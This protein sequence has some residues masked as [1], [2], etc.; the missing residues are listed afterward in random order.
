M[1]LHGSEPTERLVRPPEDYRP[2][3][4]RVHAACLLVVQLWGFNELR[5]LLPP[6]GVG[7]RNARLIFL[8]LIA[9]R[10]VLVA[11]SFPVEALFR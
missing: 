1:S 5:T 2:K 3:Y 10:C 6:L 11:L 7:A 9:V 8:G 4:R